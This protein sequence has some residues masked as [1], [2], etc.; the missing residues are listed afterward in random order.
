MRT[1]AKLTAVVALFLALNVATNLLM[2]T[3]SHAGP[4][5][6]VAGDIDGDGSVQLNDAV[7]L[8]NFLFLQGDPP[9]ACAQPSP[10]GST[11]MTPT[12]GLSNATVFT[13]ESELQGANDG[14]VLRAY[15]PVPRDGVLR[16]LTTHTHFLAYPGM[17]MIVT[18]MVN[19][20]ETTLELVTG[21]A[22]ETVMNTEVAVPV[23]AGDM[24]AFRFFA[25]NDPD[26]AM[27]IRAS[28]SFD[29]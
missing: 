25:E 2:N 27:I 10:V 17:T 13:M 6:C 26:E 9:V 28:M 4:P 1:A 15:V 11:L 22:G 18:V 21:P 3:L 19:E 14:N 20:L 29:Q 12:L 8:L 24:V 7:A 23:S 16:N 5:E